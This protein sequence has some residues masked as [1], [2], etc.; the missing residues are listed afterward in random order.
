M[1]FHVKL[2][3]LTSIFKAP[4]IFYVLGIGGFR[5]GTEGAASPRPFFL[6]FSKCLTIL[7]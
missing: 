4:A 1:L 5:G 3:S 2:I 6:V 7:L